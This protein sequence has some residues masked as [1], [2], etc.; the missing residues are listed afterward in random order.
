MMLRGIGL[1]LGHPVAVADWMAPVAEKELEKIREK[2]KAEE[3]AH[4]LPLP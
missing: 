1:Q 2:R 4:D 3:K